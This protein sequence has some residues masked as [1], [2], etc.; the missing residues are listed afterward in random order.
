MAFFKKCACCIFCCAK[1]RWWG[2]Q[3][4]KQSLSSIW[5]SVKA[6]VWQRMLFFFSTQ[7]YLQHIAQHFESDRSINI[8]FAC[9]SVHPSDQSSLSAWRNLGSLGTHWA[10]SKDRSDWVDAQADLSLH[11]AH[12]VLLG[13]V[14]LW[15]IY[16]ILVCLTCVNNTDFC[17]FE[18]FYFLK[19]PEKVMVFMYPCMCMLVCLLC[20]TAQTQLTTLH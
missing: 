6:Y 20:H 1:K 13:F 10:H 5:S 11:W 12:I 17:Y 19:L 8:T 15:L 18:A 16:N 14:M 3:E 9:P 4:M 7:I 2:C